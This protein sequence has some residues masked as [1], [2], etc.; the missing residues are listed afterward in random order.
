M[1]GIPVPPGRRAL[2]RLP[3][4]ILL[5]SILA[6]GCSQSIASVPK[7]AVRVRIAG[8]SYRSGQFTP[9]RLTVR[10]GQTVAWLNETKTQHTVTPEQFYK[11]WSD[12]GSGAI[13]PGSA[14]V[15]R[16]KRPGFYR[17]FCSFHPEM[18]GIVIVTSAKR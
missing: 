8:G 17:Y 10:A 13:S 7:T 12:G 5:L 11:D 14:Y 4:S 18:V 6:S 1:F 3:A 16:F 15:H 2:P 9:S